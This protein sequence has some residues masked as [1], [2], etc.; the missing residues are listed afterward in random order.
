LKT[1]WFLTGL[2][3]GLV[4]TLWTIAPVWA[5][6]LASW[7]FDA[8]QNFLEFTT[9][10]QVQPR[11]QLVPDPTRL[12]IDLPGTTIGNVQLS[13]VYNGAI[14]QV[15][16]AQFDPNT[17]RIVLELTP[18]YMIDPQQIRFRGLSANHWTVQVPTP[19]YTGVATAPTSPPPVNPSL[20][21]APLTPPPS[22]PTPSPD[23]QF[24]SSPIAPTP[25]PISPPITTSPPSVP[26]P[27]VDHTMTQVEGLRITDDGLFVRTRGE[28]TTVNLS[29]SRDRRSITITVNNAVLSSLLTERELSVDR[30]GVETLEFRQTED[31]PSNVQIVLSV[32][33]NSPDW[34]ASASGLGGIV[35]LPTERVIASRTRR[36]RSLEPSIE[37]S[38]PAYAAAAPPLPSAPPSAPAPASVET[39]NSPDSVDSVS[40]LPIAT[41]EGIEIDTSGRQLLIRSD[42]AVTHIGRWR[43]GLYE[44]SLSPARLA[45]RV[46]GPQLD[47]NSSLLR[48]RLRQEDDDTV[49]L[50]LQPASGV[51][52]GA[53]NAVSSQLLVL[54]MERPQPTIAAPVPPSPSPGLQPMTPN[55]P[56]PRIPSGQLVVVI[57][58][59]H[60]GAD[61][62]AVGIGGIREAD[63]VLP[64]SHQV[65]AIL[66]QQ[67]VYV[68]MT[69]NDDREIDLEPRV[70]MAEQANAT[71]FVSIHA[72]S[73]SMDRP[74]VNGAETY[75]YSSGQGLAQVIQ[76]SIVSNLGMNDRG[77]RQARFYVLRRTSMPAVLVEIGFVTGSE[78]APRLA[79]GNFRSQMARAIAQGIVLY[80]QQQA[81]VRE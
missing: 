20:S 21:P 15:R 63:I 28:T 79:D 76:N 64:I 22:A 25:S 42:R 68:V 37:S 41:I 62:G 39:A 2:L 81:L 50:I 29:R 67:G 58:P 57:D 36:S 27:S 80:I 65:A 61:V 49:V 44:I 43:S 56:L 19:E 71:L 66:Q 34:Q 55:S 33:R 47:A 70:Q 1:Q 9:S 32:D 5:G 74:D 35:L 48:L 4:G 8:T 12:V 45:D 31:N 59:G 6:E 78:D 18:G 46:S 26:S 23:S 7:R 10:E 54:A 40:S 52:F 73:I 3:S 16:I 60:G 69:R 17:T 75:Y 53:L 13:Q 38:S 30:F 11:A 77:A 51:R 72:N 14:Q 24:S